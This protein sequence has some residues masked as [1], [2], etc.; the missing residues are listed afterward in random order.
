MVS[1]SIANNLIMM[2]RMRAITRC[3]CYHLIKPQSIAEH[4]HGVALLSMLIADE[5]AEREDGVAGDINVHKLQRKA[6][7]HDFHEVYTDDI[8]WHMKHR[9]G[10]SAKERSVGKTWARKFWS[11]LNPLIPGASEL[12]G[13][14][15][16]SK[17]G[18]SMEGKIVAL[19]DMLELAL[20]LWD[21][22]LMGNTTVFVLFGDA[23]EYAARLNNDT[24]QSRIAAEIVG[25]LRGEQNVRG[26]AKK[27]FGSSE[28]N[29][30]EEHWEG[31]GDEPG[32]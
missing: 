23:T 16:D 31:D 13:D 20:Y 30:L 32:D 19:A 17:N 2:R 15:A 7:L 21:E 18:G 22:L 29:F 6:L 3:G 14:C 10:M 26:G 1:D 11:S 4:S 28:A 9:H 27:P 24:V 5:I 25:F 12:Y 8:P